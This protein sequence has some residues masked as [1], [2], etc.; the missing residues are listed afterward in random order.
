MITLP[1]RKK[2]KTPQEI[3]QK[4]GYNPYFVA[5]IQPQGGVSFKENLVRNGDGYSTCIHIYEYP[6]N[7]NDFWLEPIMNMPNAITT[8]D[9]V[10]DERKQVVEAINKNMSEQNARH[11]NAK[12]NIDRMDAQEQYLDMKELYRQVTNGEVIKRIHLRIYIAEKTIPDLEKRLKE[13]IHHLETHNFRGSIFLNE[14]EYE[15]ESLVTHFDIQKKYPNKRKGKE[16]PALALAGGF[17]FH[18]THLDDP[19]GTYQGTTRTGGSVIFDLFHKDQQRKSYNAV[20]M[21]LMGAGKSTFL[22]KVTTDN[23]IK[24]YKIRGFDIVGEFESLVR[25]LGGK[26]IALD[27]SEGQINPLQVFKTHEHEINSFTQHL[28]K[29]TVFY[30]FIAPEAKDD[31]LKEYEKLLRKL[32]IQKQLWNDEKGASNHITGLSPEAYPTFSEFLQLIRQELYADEKTREHHPN[33]GEYRKRRLELIE[34]NIE[35]LVETYAHLFDGISTIEDFN[36]EQVVFFS[37]RHLSKLKDE[38]AQAQLFNV[39]SLLWDGMLQNGEPQLA[40]YTKGTL[41]F[42]D[43]IRYLIVIDEAHHIVNTK[44]GNEHALDFLTEFSREA[45]KYFAGLIYASHLISDFVPDGS[46]QTAIEKIKKLFDLT[47][48]KFIMQ[49]DDNNLDTIQRVFK[50]GI[51]DSELAEIPKLPIGDVLLCIKSVKNILFH[52]EIDEEE[53]VLYGGGA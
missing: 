6:T 17:P 22:K 9:V 1:F 11:V 41:S 50:T 39:M 20:L 53:K 36:D 2:E 38:I 45:R 34:L 44:K 37:I 7:V 28:S 48:Y 12:E 5:Q 35:N 40:A 4:K 43:A 32:Y 42:E 18:F 33:L 25:E 15:W 49:Q 27:G 29:L 52:I 14:Q 10:S 3:K 30:R 47:Q 23:A 51:T 13:V 19:Y 21:G 26:Q 31:E 16:I 8:L 46:E 24:G